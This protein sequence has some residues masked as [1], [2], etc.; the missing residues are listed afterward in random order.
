M[1]VLNIQ[2][3][4][5]NRKTFVSV[6]NTDNGEITRET[7]FNYRQQDRMVWADY[8]GG[9]IL[10]GHLVGT[11]DDSGKLDMRYHHL[12]ENGELMTG[13]C[14]STPEI[15]DDGRIRIYERWQWTC[16]DQSIGHS[17]I[18]EVRI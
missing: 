5:Y 12:N 13:V 2:T 9:G 11:V 18:E 17:I 10:L 6:E 1:E 7:V 3:V 14:I 8:S 4:N 16:K 15:L